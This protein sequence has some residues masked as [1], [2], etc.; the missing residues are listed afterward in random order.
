MTQS[1]TLAKRPSIPVS[2]IVLPTEHGSWSFLLEPIVVGFVLAFSAAT[3][4]IALMAVGA[5]FVR[6]P[7]KTAFLANLAFTGSMVMSLL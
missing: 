5:F 7:L 2:R 4:W 6:Q 3:P 1:A